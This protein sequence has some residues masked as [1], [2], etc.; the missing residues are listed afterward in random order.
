MDWNTKVVELDLRWFF[1]EAAAACGVR[2]I[3]SGFEA[4]MDRLALCAPAEDGQIHLHET[5]GIPSHREAPEDLDAMIA[6]YASAQRALVPIAR[7]RA[8]FQRLTALEPNH[9][10][11]LEL[12]YGCAHAMGDVSLSLVCAQ[13][14]AIEGHQRAE[15]S[16]RKELERR[17]LDLARRTAVGKILRGKPEIKPKS[18]RR[19]TGGSTVRDWI[20]FLCAT[21]D[22]IEQLDAILAH[23]RLEL[24]A[25]IEAYVEAGRAQR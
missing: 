25:A 3:Q 23:A 13:H 16:A 4:A 17:N 20:F 10:R 15:S 18:R 12:Q 1:V 7:A 14:K 9:R 6:E 21:E 19:L 11:T 5:R 2:S 8:I 24:R 22:G